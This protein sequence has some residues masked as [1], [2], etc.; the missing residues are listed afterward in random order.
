MEKIILGLLML[1]GMSVYEIKSVT[2]AKLSLMCSSSAGSIHTAVKQLL[3]KGYIGCAADG[4]RKIY[5]ITATGRQ[6]FT[7][8]VTLPMNHTK[9]KNIETSKL[10]FM[11]MVAP[12]LIEGLIQKYIDSLKEER[13]SFMFFYQMS[14]D[15]KAAVL[16]ESLRLV[17]EDRWNEEGIKKNLSGRNMEQTGEDIYK[18]QMEILRYAVDSVDFEIKWYESFLERQKEK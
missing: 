3:A 4:R 12:E 14:E 13:A 5:Y 1:K 2:E 17:E 16:S 7:E 10:F 18:Y 8:W 6:A 9:A 15:N 11:G